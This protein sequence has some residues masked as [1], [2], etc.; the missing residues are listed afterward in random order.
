ML[1][2]TQITDECTRAAWS[3]LADA[4]EAFAANVARTF[5]PGSTVKLGPVVHRGR[6]ASFDLT[7]I[8]DGAIWS[9]S[10]VFPRGM[11]EADIWSLWSGT[12]MDAGLCV[13][14]D[15]TYWEMITAANDEELRRLG[16]P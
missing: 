12:F 15:P 16:M 3:D 7:G 14:D 10:I 5:T 11:C 4:H 8:V 9:F 2:S 6:Y 13:K 1:F